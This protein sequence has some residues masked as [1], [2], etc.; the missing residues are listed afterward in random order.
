MSIRPPRPWHFAWFPKSL[1][2]GRLTVQRAVGFLPAKTGTKTP[3]GLT[4]FGSGIGVFDNLNVNLTDMAAQRCRFNKW[5]LQAKSAR[6]IH[7]AGFSTR[8][9]LACPPHEAPQRALGA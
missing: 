3:D 8:S 6:L 9:V 5:V 7:V 4:A 2:D 1:P